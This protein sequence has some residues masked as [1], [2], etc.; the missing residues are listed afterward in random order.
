MADLP[1][2]DLS[3]SNFGGSDLSGADLSRANLSGVTCSATVFANVDLS[4]V[5]GLGSHDKEFARQLRSRLRDEGLRVWLDEEDMKGGRD[6]HHQIDEAIREYDKLLLILSGASMQ[7]N[8]VRTELRRARLAEKRQGVRKLF[9][10]RLVDFKLIENWELPDS[11][12]EDLAEEVRIFFIPDFSNWKDH[13]AFEAAFARLL[14]DLKD[15]ESVGASA[16]SVTPP[17]TPH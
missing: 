6:L 13:D 7:S 12:G 5:T 1:V 15:E 8:W 10:I 2:A 4:E 9:P 11:S 16:P 17:R 14:R 3:G